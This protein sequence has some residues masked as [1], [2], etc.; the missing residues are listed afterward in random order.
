[1]TDTKFL[2][3]FDTSFFWALFEINKH[4]IIEH[5]AEIF[6][7]NK[8]ISYIAP[9]TI[10]CELSGKHKDK[11][12]YLQNH[13]NFE[14]ETISDEEIEELVKINRSLKTRC[15]EWDEKGDFK[16][17]QTA[18]KHNSQDTVTAVISNDEG[19]HRFLREVIPEK[20]I[21]VIW[22][23]FFLS[24][25]SKLA[26]EKDVQDEIGSTAEILSEQ[27]ESYRS[28]LNRGIIP[29]RDFER[30][31]VYST[32]TRDLT[33]DLQNSFDSFV[34]N[35]NRNA[36]L[37][38]YLT[39]I[40]EMVIKIYSYLDLQESFIVEEEIEKLETYTMNIK[41][42]ERENV[43]CL[44]EP[45][46][47]SIF[48]KLAQIYDQEGAFSAVISALERAKSYLQYSKDSSNQSQ[49]FAILSWV[50]LLNN[51]ETLAK[52]YFGKVKDFSFEISLRV[53]TLIQLSTTPISDISKEIYDLL[54]YETWQELKRVLTIS[55]NRKIRDKIDYLLSNFGE[56]STFMLDARH[57]AIRNEIIAENQILDF[58]KKDHLLL[59]IT[60]KTAEIVVHCSNNEIGELELRLPKLEKLDRAI[61][62]DILR[63]KNGKVS[64][65]TKPR[66]GLKTKATVYFTD[67]SE[68]DLELVKK[69]KI[70]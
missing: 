7:F 46:M 13:I 57:F 21:R 15:F 12:P 23:P 65:I 53:R 67:L 35:R 30:V 45:H 34:L 69:Q 28:R 54:P 25:L 48:Y 31:L 70:I 5:V 29:I 11:L 9:K 10:L 56:K 39:K 61:K 4:T 16:I 17:I 62:G 14:T 24:F 37:P 40:G 1:M 50:H 63:I 3:I 32:P 41:I 43:Y 66:P 60:K 38:S 51:S 27:I 52:Y 8:D 22:V 47:V 55:L 18:I 20:G 19:F 44:L 58:L 49:L 68:H 26:I 2:F 59:D 33:K 6:K 42:E 64:K 36:N